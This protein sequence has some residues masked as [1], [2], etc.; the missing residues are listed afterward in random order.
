VVLAYQAAGRL[1]RGSLLKLYFGGES[2]PFGLPPTLPSLEAY[3]AMLG[4][5][6]LPW[7]VAVLGGDVVASGLARFALERGGHVRVGLEDYAGLRQPTNEE[8]VHEAAAVCKVVGAPLRRASG[9][10]ILQGH[11]VTAE[12]NRPSQGNGTIDNARAP[13]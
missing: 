12:P 8:L 3:L 9:L 4:P 2:S 5:T 6:G 7:S 1:P 11:E 10:A 13:A